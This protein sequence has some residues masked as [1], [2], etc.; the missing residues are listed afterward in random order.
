MPEEQINELTMARMPDEQINYLFDRV[1]VPMLRQRT[2]VVEEYGCEC[3][4][5]QTKYQIARRI[6]TR[7]ASA[8]T[9]RMLSMVKR[10]KE[11]MLSMAKRL[12]RCTVRARKRTDRLKSWFAK[13]RN[14]KNNVKADI[15]HRSGK[16]NERPTCQ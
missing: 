10:F 9:K 1:R 12:L 15:K 2:N 16:A 14:A 6:F 7:G 13:A 3:P 4:K 5:H 8:L 11:R